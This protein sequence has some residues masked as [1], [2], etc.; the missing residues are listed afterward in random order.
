MVL[1]T[2]KKYILLVPSCYLP[3]VATEWHFTCLISHLDLRSF[4]FQPLKFTYTLS[5]QLKTILPAVV[6]YRLWL[7]H[8]LTF[9]WIKPL[10][11]L[12]SSAPHISVFKFCCSFL[13]PLWFDGQF[14]AGGTAPNTAFLCWL[15]GDYGK[16]SHHLPPPTWAPPDNCIWSTD[17]YWFPP[18]YYPNTVHKENQSFT[19]ILRNGRKLAAHILPGESDLDRPI[20]ITH[21]MGPEGLLHHTPAHQAGGEEASPWCWEG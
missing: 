11:T 14:G 1:H 18:F 16:G 9:P 6:T 3:R 10:N 15:I 19:W 5:L 17:C 8:L 7:G 4:H 12:A 20:A 21:V 2:G 13:N